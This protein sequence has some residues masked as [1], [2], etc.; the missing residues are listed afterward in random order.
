MTWV[1]LVATV[2]AM[3]LVL[4]V[5][6]MFAFTNVQAARSQHDLLD[7]FHGSSVVDA[8]E[9]KP[10]ANGEPAAILKVPALDLDQV[11]VEGTSSGDLQAGPGLM[12]RTAPPGV[13]GNTVI[14]GRRLTFGHPF[15]HLLSLVPGDRVYVTGSYGRFTYRVVRVG[16]A[17]PGE[18]D[19]V[20]P[21]ADARPDACHVGAALQL[22]S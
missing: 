19:P 16:I 2:V 8:L 6:Y 1:G 21:S 7:S 5:G 17:S 13:R 20:G 18:P 22:G 15:E 9:G 4:F 12:P 10:P 11:V 3:V 14:A